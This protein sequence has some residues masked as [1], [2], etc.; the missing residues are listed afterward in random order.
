MPKSTFCGG[1]DFNI[2]GLHVSVLLLLSE[3]NWVMKVGPGSDW[4]SVDTNTNSIFS[5]NYW[6]L[7]CVLA[8]ILHIMR[9]VYYFLSF[10]IEEIDLKG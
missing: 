4:L 6:D 1:G 10:T 2:S 5:G 8:H 7:N 9:W 3:P